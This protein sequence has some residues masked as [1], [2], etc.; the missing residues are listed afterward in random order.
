MVR[1]IPRYSILVYAVVNGIV[2]LISLSDNSLLVYRN[3][4]DFFEFV[5]F[6]Y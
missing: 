2:F 1:F 3:V 5:G 6:V 4:I